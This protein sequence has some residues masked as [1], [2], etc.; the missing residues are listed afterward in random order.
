MHVND[1]ADIE[2]SVY[3]NIAM[4]IFSKNLFQFRVNLHHIKPSNLI[5]IEYQ[6]NW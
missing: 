1:N 3:S 6:E 5:T 2:I 4:K